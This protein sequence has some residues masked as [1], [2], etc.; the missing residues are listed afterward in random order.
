MDRLTKSVQLIPKFRRRS[1]EAVSFFVEVLSW[2]CRE[3]NEQNKTFGRK[4]DVG[5][6]RDSEKRKCL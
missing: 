1:G 4:E 6:N 3:G 5:S 2:N